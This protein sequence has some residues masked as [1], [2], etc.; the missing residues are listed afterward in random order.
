M[1]PYFWLTSFSLPIRVVSY[2]LSLFNG[3]TY[4]V[5]TVDRLFFI[6]LLISFFFFLNLVHEWKAFCCYKKSILFLKE[7]IA[8]T[9]LFF[10]EWSI[11]QLWDHGKRIVLI[12]TLICHTNWSVWWRS[13]ERNGCSQCFVVVE[14]EYLRWKG[15]VFACT[16]ALQRSSHFNAQASIGKGG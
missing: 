14:V 10:I 16:L 15:K 12:V 1:G 8:R 11:Y 9:I 2:S 5:I 7:N 4:L 3:S 13:R 6:K